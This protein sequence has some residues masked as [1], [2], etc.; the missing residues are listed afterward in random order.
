M[1]NELVDGARENTANFDK[2]YYID[3]TLGGCGHTLSLLQKE[4][5]SLVIGVDQDQDALD[6]AKS[7]LKKNNVMER[8]HLVKS[9]FS[10]I[11]T[12]LN[13]SKLF[14]IGYQLGGVIADIG[15]SSH[16]FDEKERGFSFRF[17]GPLDMRMNYSEP[18][19]TAAD[20]INDY[21]EES[22]VE[23]FKKYGE[24]K[25]AGRIAE[26]IC[27]VRAEEKIVTTRQLENIVFHCYPKKWRHGRTHPATRVFQ[28]LRIFVNKELEVLEKVIPSVISILPAGSRFGIIT[29]HSLEDRIV[30]HTFR[31]FHRQKI[32]EL[33]Q[34][35]PI[36]PSEEE[37]MVNPRSRSAKLRMVTKL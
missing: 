4:Q 3:L 16:Q 36:L 35:K 31:D 30:K 13:E 9:N 8:V 1:L 12:V 15:V 17:D 26:S 24:E 33:V 25:L 23:I 14:T 20:V 6:N 19:E 37:L 7:F 29:F 2:K 18:G 5:E 34:R 21:D 11:A 10:D 22:L 27:K 28:A 32:V